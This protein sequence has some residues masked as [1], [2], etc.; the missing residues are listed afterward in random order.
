MTDPF[1]RGGADARRNTVEAAQTSMR[2]DHL[3][4]L[5][6]LCSIICA[7]SVVGHGVE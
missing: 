4:R 6:A 7:V 1:R 2:A 5:G 3:R